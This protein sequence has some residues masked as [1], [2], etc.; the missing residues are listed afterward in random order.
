MSDQREQ[1][2]TRDYDFFHCPNQKSEKYLSIKLEPQELEFINPK[3]P[4]R[5]TPVPYQNHEA[6]QA[7]RVHLFNNTAAPYKPPTQGAEL[8]EK[9]IAK[10]GSYLPFG[11]VKKAEVVTPTPASPIPE[12]PK[13]TAPK[14]DHEITKTKPPMESY[15]RP[16]MP[17]TSPPPLTNGYDNQVPS[18]TP[19]PINKTKEKPSYTKHFAFHSQ[20]SNLHVDTAQLKSP[21]MDL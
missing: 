10:V 19:K 20:E 17:S 14:A 18:K 2:F 11:I 3:T 13:V 8:E 21:G 15:K 1:N 12:S 9:P 16:P 4:H 7:K 5:I 6:V